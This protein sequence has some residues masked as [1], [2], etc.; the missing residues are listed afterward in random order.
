MSTRVDQIVAVLE[1]VWIRRALL[2]VFRERA[3]PVVA[4]RFGVEPS[5]VHDK[6]VRQLGP[7][8]ATAVDFDRLLVRW[9]GG[10][11]EP[12]R[13]VLLR[14]ALDRSD[15]MRIETFFKEVVPARAS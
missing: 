4:E 2:G 8:V 13:Q 10:D 7:D 15:E 1:E 11:G 3:V 14:H 5:T 12:L 9:L 6:L